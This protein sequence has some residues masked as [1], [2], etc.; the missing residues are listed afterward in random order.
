[1]P[2][3]LFAVQMIY[4]AIRNHRLFPSN[5]AHIALCLSKLV[6]F[7]YFRLYKG[8][9]VQFKSEQYTMITSLSCIAVLIIIHKFQKKG[10]P[11]L[12]LAGYFGDDNKHDYFLDSDCKTMN[13]FAD[14]EICP[15]CFEEYSNTNI[16]WDKE[17]I[18]LSDNVKEY[19]KQRNSPLMKT[20]CSHIFH[21]SCLISVMNFNMSCPT[22]RMPL[23]Q[24]T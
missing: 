7:T 21:T 13:S 23:P 1:M 6:Y 16:D 20:P 12:L 2:P 18:E 5:S 8:N 14:D 9:F 19:V 15:V 3:V 11:R 24:I 22:C 10:S 17:L 4:L